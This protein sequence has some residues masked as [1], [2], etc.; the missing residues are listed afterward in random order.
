MP[1]MKEAL[2]SVDT[3]S[4][5]LDAEADGKLHML[6]G[7]TKVVQHTSPAKTSVGLRGKSISLSPIL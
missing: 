2:E 1:Q 3:G 5:L 6:F 7:G 4:K